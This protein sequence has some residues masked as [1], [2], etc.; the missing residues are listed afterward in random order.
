V[1]LYEKNGRPTFGGGVSMQVFLSGFDAV[2]EKTV[3]SK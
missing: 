2:R 3:R 1:H